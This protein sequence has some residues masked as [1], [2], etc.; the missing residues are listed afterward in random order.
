MQAS[1][2]VAKHANVTKHRK[3]RKR[4][5]AQENMQMFSSGKTGKRFKATENIETL[6]NAGK[7]AGVSKRGKTYRC[8]QAQENRQT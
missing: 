8:F 3:T 5:Q 6:T 7:Q 1:P 2:G 4:Y